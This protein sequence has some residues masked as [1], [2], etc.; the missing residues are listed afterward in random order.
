MSTE[1]LKAV[2]EIEDFP[3]RTEIISILNN[4][5]KSYSQNMKYTTINKYNALTV[6]FP[7]SVNFNINSIFS[8]T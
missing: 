1:G 3:S 8:R 4:F 6:T 2:I 5:L 7:D